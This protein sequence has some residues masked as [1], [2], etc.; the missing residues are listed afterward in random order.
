MMKILENEFAEF[1]TNFNME[2]KDYE[3]TAL[4]PLV[5]D[6][7]NHELMVVGRAL[8]KW[9]NKEDNIWWKCGEKPSSKIIKDIIKFSGMDGGKCSMKWITEN[10]DSECNGTYRM[11]KSAF[12]RVVK[13]ILSKLKITNSDI[14]SSYLVWTNL[15]KIAPAQG[16]N[17]TEK[18]CKAQLGNCLSLLKNE[19]DF[20]KPKRILFLTGYDWFKD[21]EEV[22]SGKKTHSGNLVEWKGFLGKIKIVVAKHPERK[23]ETKYVQQVVK[24]F[25]SL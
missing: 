12:W 2:V 18:M 16:G 22:F 13:N 10:W 19:I 25:S 1:L 24:T 23:D 21:F 15:Y 4:F 7:Y 3:L 14:W 9:G 5:G 8:N 17:P 11:N 20:F 6:K